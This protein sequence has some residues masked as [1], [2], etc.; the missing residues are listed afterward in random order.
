MLIVTY[1]LVTL[2]VEQEK[3]RHLLSALQQ[4]VQQYC[5][6]QSQCVEIS[7]LEPILNQLMQFDDAC[8]HRNVEL[9]IIPAIRRAT[10]EANALLA[11]LQAGS[12]AGS[13]LLTSVRERLQQPGIEHGI[14]TVNELASAM[15]SYCRQLHGRLSREEVELFPIARRVIT[16]EEE[17]FAIAAQFISHDET[18]HAYQPS[19]SMRAPVAEK[20]TQ[21]PH[22]FTANRSAPLM[23]LQH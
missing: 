3:T 2:T 6:T 18:A 12:S 8:R 5:A 11:E 1:S 19:A 9:Y 23:E 16:S 14:R 13:H 21:T 20:Y 10:Q 22:R 4:R 15:E 17:W 7:E